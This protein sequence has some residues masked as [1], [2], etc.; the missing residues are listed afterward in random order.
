MRSSSPPF[1]ATDDNITDRVFDIVVGLH[2]I[3][4]VIGNQRL[5][6]LGVGRGNRGVGAQIVAKKQ[7]IPLIGAPGQPDMD[8][9]E[10][11]CWAGLKKP[12]LISVFLSVRIFNIPQRCIIAYFFNGTA[13]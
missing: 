2:I 1:G 8:I 7:R 10:A 9:G 4:R 3:F 13:L 12:F 11:L 5:F 6:D